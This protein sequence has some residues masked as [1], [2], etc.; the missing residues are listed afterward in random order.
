[1]SSELPPSLDPATARERQYWI[2]AAM[3]VRGDGTKA[4]AAAQAAIGQ[5]T[6]IGNDELTWRLA[7]L[8]SA[9]ARAEGNLQQQDAL[10]HIAVAALGRLRVSWGD[11]VRSYLQ[12]P[13]LIEL[14]KLSGMED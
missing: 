11:H 1:V 2:V 6:K 10:R 9:A 3:L 7:A 5:A 13:D 8:G 12:R 4:R 14:R